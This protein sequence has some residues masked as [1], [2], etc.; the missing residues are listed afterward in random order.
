[1]PSTFGRIETLFR[2]LQAQQLAVDTVN[3]N[4]AN[5]NTP[6]YSRQRVDFQTTP[7][8]SVP[9]FN[10]WDSAG[11]IGTGVAVA[12]VDR[13]RIHYLDLQ[14]RAQ[15]AKMGDAGSRAGVYQTV[16]AVFNEPNETGLNA[17]ID[18]FWGAWQSLVNRPDDPATRGYVIEEATN[19]AANINRVR[20][21]IGIARTETKLSL[22][23][24]ISEVNALAKDIADLNTQIT[25]VRGVNQQPADLS[26]KRD[27]LLDRLS[28]LVQT[29]NI[30][31]P[32]GA[33]N[34]YIGGTALVDREKTNAIA[35]SESGD[36]LSVVWQRDGKA[37]PISGGAVSGQL[38]MYNTE[39]PAALADVNTLRNGIVNAVNGIHRTGYGQN[40]P[41]GPAP[42]RNFFRILPDGEMRVNP[43]IANDPTLLAAASRPGEPGNAET[44]LA[45]A[46]IR[47]ELTMNA[48]TATISDF[49]NSMVARIGGK[50]RQAETTVAN[51]DTLVQAVDRQ[52]QQV[53]QVSLDEE[54]VN[55]IKF[56]QAYQAAARAM[57]VVDEMLSTIITGMGVVGR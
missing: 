13:V 47:N 25:A 43:A 6:G 23:T 57:T 34:V 24:N 32:D 55:L 48:G 38:A 8:Y 5:A 10:R 30:M 4:I 56:Q 52:R 42:N 39:L 9:T 26:D 21:Q 33:I 36:T 45:I 51:Q 3:H 1:M 14:Y 22:E 20:E 16:E 27:L 18:R 44:A 53:S 15:N 37:T 41:A 50:A 35:T 29:N 7:P 12:S 40:D 46:N 49:Y 54:A 31:T 17:F 28:E 11:Q 19:L 2:G